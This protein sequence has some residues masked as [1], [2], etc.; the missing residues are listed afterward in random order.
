MRLQQIGLSVAGAIVLFSIVLAGATAWLFLTSPVTVATSAGDSGA[1]DCDTSYPARRGL[2]VDV[3]SSLPYVTSIERLAREEG[4]EEGL[5]KG[6]QEGEAVG[7]R[8]GIALALEIN[9]AIAAHATRT[10]F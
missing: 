2:A 6:R 4:L 1:A 10:G 8:Q 5:Q 9:R 3:P 7:L